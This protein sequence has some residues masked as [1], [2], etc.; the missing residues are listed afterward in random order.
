MYIL[1]VD[2]HTR[3]KVHGTKHDRN[4]YSQNMEFHRRLTFVADNNNV[5]IGLSLKCAYQHIETETKWPPFPDDIF[6]WIFL[7][8]NVWVLLKISLKLA[9]KGPINNIPALFQIMAWRRPGDKPLSETMMVSLPTH[10]CVTR[11]Q[12]VKHNASYNIMHIIHMW[13]PT[14]F[15]LDI[16]NHYIFIHAAS[17]FNKILSKQFHMPIRD[18]DNVKLPW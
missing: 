11:P 14:S 3:K 13:L 16:V 1:K 18:F 12:W 9:P 5:C 8:E 2:H 15:S 4:K 6:I 7:N 10:I 17:M